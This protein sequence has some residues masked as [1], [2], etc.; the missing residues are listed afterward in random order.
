MNPHYPRAKHIDIHFA[1]APVP[2]MPNSTISLQQPAKKP[3]P[4]STQSP[5]KSKNIVTS[6]KDLT[7]PFGPNLSPTKL[8]DLLKE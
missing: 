1:L 3:T 4:L 2:T 8:V 5:A 6:S 7:L